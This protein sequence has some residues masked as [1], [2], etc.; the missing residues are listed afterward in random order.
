MAA[1]QKSGVTAW[2]YEFFAEDGRFPLGRPG[3]QIAGIQAVF[4]GAHAL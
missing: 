4:A 2:S 1:L 3:G